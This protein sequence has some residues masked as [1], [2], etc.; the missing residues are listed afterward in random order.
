MRVDPT[1]ERVVAVFFFAAKDAAHVERI[2]ANGFNGWDRITAKLPYGKPTFV[3]QPGILVSDA[4][5]PSTGFAI[6]LEF[7]TNK[8][9]LKGLELMSHVSG[10]RYFVLMVGDTK[11][12]RLWKVAEDE[13]AKAREAGLEKWQHQPL[14]W[15][16]KD[17]MKVA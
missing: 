12:A 7:A 6:G 17:E 8:G 16:G 13:L 11:K 10:V 15:F 4:P 14:V 2:L 3:D 5:D 1:I 9:Y